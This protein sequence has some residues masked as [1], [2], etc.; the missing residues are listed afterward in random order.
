MAVTGLLAPSPALAADE[1][2]FDELTIGTRTY[3]NVTVT[4]KSKTYVFLIHSGGMANIKVSEISDETL[5]K[6]G[7][8]KEKP[9]PSKTEVFT[10]QT[11]AKIQTPEVKEFEKKAAEAWREQWDKCRQYLPEQTVPVVAGE[12]A[13]LFLG[14][15][16]YSLCCM[17][18]C[19]KAGRPG[20]AL[21]WFPVLKIIPLLRAAGMS[22]ALF[23]V[24]LIPIANFILAIVWAFKIAVARGKSP[25]VGF[26]MLVPVI[27]LFVFLN[28][29]FSPAAENSSAQKSV[30]RGGMRLK[31][32]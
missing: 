9:K 10:S 22:P 20:G 31:T 1:L 15:I 18:I 3:T 14:Y 29:A 6:L 32:A 27:N 12:A 11:I 5:A 19:Q 21:V 17:L 16:F 24:A 4:T 13:G 23:L 2:K 30:S 8:E 25:L 28:L 7:I 26:L